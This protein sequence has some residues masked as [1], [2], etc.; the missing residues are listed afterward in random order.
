MLDTYIEKLDYMKGIV[1][2]AAFNGL[3]DADFQ[4]DH[5]LLKIKNKKMK[6]WFKSGNIEQF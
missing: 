1:E 3:V 4:P 6:I 2:Q 5:L